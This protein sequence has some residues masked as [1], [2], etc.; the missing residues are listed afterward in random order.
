MFKA[1]RPIRSRSI[2]LFT[3]TQR[4]L[5]KTISYYSELF[6]MAA[7]RC[8]YMNKAPANTLLE[9]TNREWLLPINEQPPLAP[10][11]PTE[12]APQLHVQTPLPLLCPLLPHRPRTGPRDHLHHCAPRRHRP[13][14]PRRHILPIHQR[15]QSPP[16]SV[17]VHQRSALHRVQPRPLDFKLSRPP[18]RH[19]VPRPFQTC[20]RSALAV[21]YISR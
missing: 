9:R 4:R 20:R 13:R 21:S 6:R 11:L 18:L 17:A 10:T 19:P 1:F 2:K 14:L 8:E 7:D 15:K 16:L 12:K 5:A 3:R